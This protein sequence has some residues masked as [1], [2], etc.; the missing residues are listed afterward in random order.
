MVQLQTYLTLAQIKQLQVWV[1]Q[2][3]VL[4]ISTQE[5]EMVLQVFG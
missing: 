1:F 4:V 5:Q 3:Q 2:T